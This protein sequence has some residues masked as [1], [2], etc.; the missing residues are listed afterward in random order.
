MDMQFRDGVSEKDQ[1]HIKI[2]HLSTD[3]IFD[4]T[5]VEVSEPYLAVE[6][7]VDFSESSDETTLTFYH[8]LADRYGRSDVE[9]KLRGVAIVVPRSKLIEL[10]T[11]L[12]TTLTPTTEQLILERLTEIAERLKQPRSR[13]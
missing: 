5:G 9:T 2:Q 7:D 10:A 6:I 3:A 1:L 11:R 8:D 4:T 13:G 12:L